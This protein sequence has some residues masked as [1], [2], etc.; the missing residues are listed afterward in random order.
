MAATSSRAGFGRFALNGMG[1]RH[2]G[3]MPPTT[4]ASR[5]SGNIPRRPASSGSSVLAVVRNRQ[6][7][8]V[9]ATSLCRPCSAG[10]IDPVGITNASAS[11]VRMKNASTN[12]TTI[13]S[14]V[15]RNT[16]NCPPGAADSAAAVEGPSP[17]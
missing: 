10:D 14:I 17:R 2:I 12:A 7:H 3:H 6:P 4:S 8:C 11:N 16:T 9:H 5:G 15:S 1:Y 13:D